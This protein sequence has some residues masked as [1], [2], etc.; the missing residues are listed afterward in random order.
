MNEVNLENVF[1]NIDVDKMVQI[2]KKTIMT[3]LC[4]FIPHETVRSMNK[5]IK[6]ANHGKK[7]IFNCFHRSNNDKQLLDRFTHLIKC[8]H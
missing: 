1:S 3:I 2:F 6:K 8:Y 5:E 7:N 4:N